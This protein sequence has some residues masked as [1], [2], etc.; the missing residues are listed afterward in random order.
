MEVG[1]YV[2]LVSGWLQTHTNHPLFFSTNNGLAQMALTTAGNV[3]IGTITPGFPL[4]VAGTIHSTI[5]GFRFPDGTVQTT[6]L[7]AAGAGC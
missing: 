5:G 3:G 6:G 7:S 1:T 4:T 2:D